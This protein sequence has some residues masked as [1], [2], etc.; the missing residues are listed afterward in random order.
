MSEA[1]IEIALPEALIEAIT[2]EVVTRV[3]TELRR[4]QARRWL[5]IKDAAVELGMSAGALRKHV[6]RGSVKADRIGNRIVVDMS[7]IGAK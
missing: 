4:D 5:P 3:L 2:A 7:A 1:R 6:E